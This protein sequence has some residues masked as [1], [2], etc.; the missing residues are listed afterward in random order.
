MAK[1]QWA[2]EG[3]YMES[4]NCDYLCPCIF[5]NPQ[6]PVTHDHCYAMLVYRIDEGSHNDTS[7]DGLKFA[8]IIRSRKVMSDGDWIFGCV[9]DADADDSQ[10]A[11]LSTIVSGEAG[12]TPALIHENLVGDFRGIEIKPIEF[13]MDGLVRA[14]EIPDVLSF[15]IEGVASRNQSGEPYYIDNTAHPSN[16]RLALARSKRS[17]LGAFGLE[18]DMTGKGNNAH[19][20]PFH[21]TA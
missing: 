18:L 1:P 20:A 9:V 14:A 15:E 12:G 16:R 3:Q 21:W 5:T 13:T 4:C 2:L 8:F 6:A 10:R 7:L 11:A 19:F 17:R